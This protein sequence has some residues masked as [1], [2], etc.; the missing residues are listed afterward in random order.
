MGKK[1]KR[2][3]ASVM[4]YFEKNPTSMKVKVLV[5]SN[6]KEY[7]YHFCLRSAMWDIKDITGLIAKRG[8]SNSSYYNDKRVC[9]Q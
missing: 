1:L 6:I 4:G 8:K 2:S 5:E 9:Y 3:K 7:M